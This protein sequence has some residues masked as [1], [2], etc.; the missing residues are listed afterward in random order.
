MSTCI[1]TAAAIIF[2]MFPVHLI[3]Y[4]LDNRNITDYCKGIVLLSLTFISI[5][6]G[7]K[8]LIYAWV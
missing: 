4:L 3:G 6:I 2:F 8:L 7:I 1:G 5:C